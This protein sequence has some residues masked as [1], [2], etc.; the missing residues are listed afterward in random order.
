MKFHGIRV[1]HVKVIVYDKTIR[2]SSW[3]FH[4]HVLQCGKM[5]LSEFLFSLDLWH[6]LQS[7]NS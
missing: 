4:A 1:L 7:I 2:Y 5:S 3:N 6:S